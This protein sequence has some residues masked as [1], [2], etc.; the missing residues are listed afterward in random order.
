[1]VETASTTACATMSG[2]NSETRF[3]SSTRTVLFVLA[4]RLKSIHNDTREDHARA[5]DSRGRARAHTH[6]SI[7]IARAFSS[8]AEASLRFR[9]PRWR[10]VPS[11]RRRYPRRTSRS[12]A[13][14]AAERLVRKRRLVR[15]RR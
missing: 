12:S 15:V 8:N 13:T 10:N 7:V 4:V 1:M 11:R 9:S 14:R 6:A 3:G 2:Q 5:R